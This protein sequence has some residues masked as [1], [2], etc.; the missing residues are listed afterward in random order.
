MALWHSLGVSLPSPLGVPTQLCM[1][2]PSSI[3]KNI[4]ESA[5][6][7]IYGYH[8]GEWAHYSIPILST[9]R[10]PVLR[11]TSGACEVEPVDVPPP[12]SGGGGSEGGENCYAYL[13]TISVDDGYGWVIVD[14]FIVHFCD[15]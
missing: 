2:Y 3:A 1:I 6:W 13:I 14:Q 5:S 10:G 11:S 15:P 4:E 9:I 7:N 12:G 8:Y